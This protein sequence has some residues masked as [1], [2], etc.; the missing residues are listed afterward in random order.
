MASDYRLEACACCNVVRLVMRPLIRN[1]DAE[2]R[3]WVKS[4]APWPTTIEVCSDCQKERPA[5]WDS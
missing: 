4:D 2:R 5:R 3:E 1:S